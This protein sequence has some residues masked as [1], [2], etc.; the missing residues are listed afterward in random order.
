MGKEREHVWE[1]KG[2]PLEK[3]NL[4]SRL[5]IDERDGKENEGGNLRKEEKHH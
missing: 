5:V 2:T 3:W 4:D 1:R